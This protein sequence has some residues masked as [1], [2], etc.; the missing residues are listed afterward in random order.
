MRFMFK[1]L[2]ITVLRD[3]VMAGPHC[4]SCSIISCP[5]PTVNCGPLTC[6]L[7]S[8]MQL[9]ASAESL[10]SLKRELQIALAQVEAVEAATR[11][12]NQ[13]K[14]FEEAEFVE[15]RLAEALETVRQQKSTLLRSGT[16]E[17]G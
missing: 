13:P 8:V 10:A 7:T 4:G 11:E 9:A 5:L 16:S 6:P 12:Q 2:M 17:E 14:S 3:D 1:D 15:R